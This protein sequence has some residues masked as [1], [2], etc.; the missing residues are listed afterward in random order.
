M[1]RQVSD[2]PQHFVE[3]RFFPTAAV[4][5][6]GS[7]GLRGSAL[8]AVAAFDAADDFVAVAARDL[9]FGALMCW[10]LTDGV[11]GF[12]PVSR[13]IP[14]EK[15]EERMATSSRRRKMFPFGYIFLT[16]NHLQQN[17]PVREHGANM[18]KDQSTVDRRASKTALTF[19]S[20]IRS[21]RKAMNMRQDQLALAT[22]V[23]RRFL[24]DLE[25]GKP[26]CQLGRSL[27]VADALGLRLTDIMASGGPSSATAWELPD[28]PEEVEEPDGQSTRI[29]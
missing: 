28:L 10:S 23:G 7:F 21:R 26:S 20:L 4:F 29:L 25:A 5:S 6:F 27:L 8:L 2:R 16:F 17:I 24:I 19:G 22:G 12:W 9:R 18:D 3:I 15:T 1:S 13:I 11:Q 14:G